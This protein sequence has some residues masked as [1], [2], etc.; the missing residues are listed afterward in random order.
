MGLKPAFLLGASDGA[1]AQLFHGA[2]R[3]RGCL[4]RAFLVSKGSGRGRPLYV[5]AAGW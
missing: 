2:A 5:G 3:H 4:L 1:E